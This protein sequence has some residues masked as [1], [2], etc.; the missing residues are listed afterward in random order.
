M[1]TL[2]WERTDTG[3]IATLRLPNALYEAFL[4]SYTVRGIRENVDASRFLCVLCTDSACSNT[5]RDCPNCRIGKAC[6]VKNVDE[7]L[8]LIPEEIYTA[9]QNIGDGLGDSIDVQILRHARRRIRRAVV[10][11]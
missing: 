3:E 11:R 1:V 10:R 7:C 6:G 5:Y 2:R 9:R 8:G 4:K